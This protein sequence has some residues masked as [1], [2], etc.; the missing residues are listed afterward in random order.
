VSVCLSAF[1]V[2]KHLGPFNCTFLGEKNTIRK[3]SAWGCCASFQFRNWLSSVK[4]MTLWSLTPCFEPTFEPKRPLAE[5]LGPRMTRFN[6]TECQI[7]CSIVKVSSLGTLNLNLPNSYV[8]SIRQPSQCKYSLMSSVLK[9][10]IESVFVIMSGQ[11]R[12]NRH[13]WTNG[14]AS[15]LGKG[16]EIVCLKKLLVK[17]G[18]LVWSKAFKEKK[19]FNWRS[20]VQTKAIKVKKLLKVK[21]GSPLQTKLRLFTG[22]PPL[23]KR[24]KF[25]LER[26]TKLR[27]Q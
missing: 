9:S 12:R 10:P 18:S 2:P 17:V 5:S 3:L 22:D 27:L 1:H 25:G 14:V 13:P 7:Y 11:K 23:R 24:T 16:N 6:S 21:F 4:N 26:W 19:S 20:L 15:Q 8:Q